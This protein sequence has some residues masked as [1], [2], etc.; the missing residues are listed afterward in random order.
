MKISRLS[1]GYKRHLSYKI[2]IIAKQ[3]KM[4]VYLAVTFSSVNAMQL[5]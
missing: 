5:F 1:Q 4:K 2:P 3:N